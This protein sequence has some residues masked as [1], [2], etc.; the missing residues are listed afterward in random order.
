[1]GHA[2]RE[3][4]VAIALAR[5]AQVLPE[6]GGLRRGNNL[7]AFEQFDP[8]PATWFGAGDGPTTNF[9]QIDHINAV[10]DPGLSAAWRLGVRAA[11]V[12]DGE[13]GFEAVRAFQG[14]VMTGQQIVLAIQG[15]METVVTLALAN[16][17]EIFAEHVRAGRA[18]QLAILKQF[19]FKVFVG[20]TLVPDPSGYDFVIGA[21]DIVLDGGAMS[22]L[23]L[24]SR[25]AGGAKSEQGINLFHRNSHLVRRCRRQAVR[26]GK[27]KI[28]SSVGI[29]SLR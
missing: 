20:L 12:F 19:H 23:S 14:D 8:E 13:V 3:H 17:L 28:P 27:R 10:I 1:M 4:V 16:K 6:F 21:I 9:V 15:D 5:I 24:A 26:R 11:L 7:A 29:A 22:C 18:D 2:N 25:C